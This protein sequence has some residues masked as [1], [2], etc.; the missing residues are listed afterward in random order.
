MTD[1]ADMK[2]GDEVVSALEPAQI[3]AL[4]AL[5]VAVLLIWRAVRRSD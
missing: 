5:A 1:V 4:I 2:D 3:G